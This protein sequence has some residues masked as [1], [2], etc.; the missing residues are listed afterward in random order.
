MA[1][2]LTKAVA[3][4]VKGPNLTDADRAHLKRWLSDDYAD[5]PI[6][7]RLEKEA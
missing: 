1:K 7:Q 5:H 4:V 6:W 2:A 3:T